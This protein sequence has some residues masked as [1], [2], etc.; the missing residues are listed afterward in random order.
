MATALT[1][2]P[3]SLM[4]PYTMQA[5][6]HLQEIY[7]EDRLNNFEQ[8]STYYN[9]LLAAEL[10][11]PT[12]HNVTLHVRL[13]PFCSA[14]TRLLVDVKADGWY[15]TLCSDLGVTSLKTRLGKELSSLSFDELLAVDSILVTT[16]TPLAAPTSL[17]G[18]LPIEAPFK[19]SPSRGE[20][21]QLWFDSAVE[22]M[23]FAI[24]N[25]IH[26]T[27]PSVFEHT[28]NPEAA[29][30]G[31][32]MGLIGNKK[33]M[34]ALLST[35][36]GQVDTS[37]WIDLGTISDKT[38]Q[39]I[40]A[41][42]YRSLINTVSHNETEMR[43]ALIQDALDVV[44]Q[45]LETLT[46]AKKT[47]L[48]VA[49]LTSLSIVDRAL[50]AIL[51]DDLFETNTKTTTV[52]VTQSTTVSSLD[53]TLKNT[54]VLQMDLAGIIDKIKKKKADWD[55]KRRAKKAD[56][57][58]KYAALKPYNDRKAAVAKEKQDKIRTKKA[59]K[60]AKKA[61]AKNVYSQLETTIG[62][63]IIGQST[64]LVAVHIV[65]QIGCCHRESHYHYHQ[66]HHHHPKADEPKA[67]EP[68]ADE[69]KAAEPKADEPKAAEPKADEPKAAEPKAAEPKAAEPKAAEPKAAEPESVP[70]K[71]YL[72]NMLAINAVVNAIIPIAASAVPIAK[73][74]T[75]ATSSVH[76]TAAVAANTAASTA[77]PVM[78]MTEFRYKYGKDYGLTM[79]YLFSAPASE[80]TGSKSI[81]MF[82]DDAFGVNTN[83]KSIKESF[84][85]KPVDTHIDTSFILEGWGTGSQVFHMVK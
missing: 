64:E 17:E 81:A 15:Q 43:A 42:V 16:Q 2:S 12:S 77:I 18:F 59:L 78:R 30:W 8:F 53:V 29:L 67:A 27:L 83:I 49:G 82:K 23:A 10:K 3:T 11:V 36:F 7:G 31:H 61:N 66:H 62:N 50:P 58:E 70:A 48:P 56:K 13:N 26:N 44:Q 38:K 47:G 74:Q 4:H 85:K 73:T 51:D 37:E 1:L 65:N 84:D 68:K 76:V 5:F 28:A 25:H 24:A 75:P 63:L 41:H 46:E 32:V 21:A 39:D 80:F 79:R 45:R 14:H 71:T 57:S 54:E 9:N 33:D 34:Q 20:Y 6:A 69:P 22:T 40:M 19:Y 52:P 60:D 72:P 35:A 55:A